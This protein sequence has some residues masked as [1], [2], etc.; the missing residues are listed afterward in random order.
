MSPSLL[1]WARW[2]VRSCRGCRCVRRVAVPCCWELSPESTPGPQEAAAS[3]SL[4]PVGTRRKGNQTL[5]FS[6]QVPACACCGSQ[7]ARGGCCIASGG[8]HHP[9]R[10]LKVPGGPLGGLAFRLHACPKEGQQAHKRGG[11]ASCSQR[12][13]FGDSINQ[14]L[15]GF[16]C[17]AKKE[18]SLNSLGACVCVVLA[19]WYRGLAWSS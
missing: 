6:D 8:K 4:G 13:R 18:F 1:L 12:Q 10:S 11:M 16:H 7:L 2:G 5:S 9:L 17:L 3:P 19:V 15:P 14:F